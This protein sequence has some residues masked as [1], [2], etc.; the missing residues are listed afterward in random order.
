V[1][2]CVV[3]MSDCVD[4]WQQMTHQ[5]YEVEVGSGRSTKRKKAR[6]SSLFEVRRDIII[7][8]LALW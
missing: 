7:A 2:K 4:V 1:C 5:E 8:F 6:S 3:A